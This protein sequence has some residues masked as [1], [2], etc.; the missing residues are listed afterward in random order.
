[1]N[2]DNANFGMAWVIDE[3]SKR[4]QGVTMEVG[5]QRFDTEKHKITVFDALS[6]ADF[7]LQMIREGEVLP[8][9]VIWWLIV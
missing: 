4:E 1:M 8:T 9:L 2:I 5:T 6:Q 7:I 3:D